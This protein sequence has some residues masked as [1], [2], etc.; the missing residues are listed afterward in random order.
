MASGVYDQTG[1]VP[2]GQDEQMVWRVRPSLYDFPYRRVVYFTHFTSRGQTSLKDQLTQPQCTRLSAKPD[3]PSFLA[4]GLNSANERPLDRP[5]EKD[6]SCRL[7]NA[8][9]GQK[10]AQ[11]TSCVSGGYRLDEDPQDKA[12]GKQLVCC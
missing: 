5:H 11:P 9:D 8:R 12:A 4:S 1:L 6:R 2:T 3:H 7:R 10:P